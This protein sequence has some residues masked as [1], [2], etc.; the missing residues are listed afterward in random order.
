M[1]KADRVPG[2]DS[3]LDYVQFI[4]FEKAGIGA[5]ESRCIEALLK[6]GFWRLVWNGEKQAFFLER[7]SSN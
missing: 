5:E 2:R 7:K 6:T 4:W 1:E 3:G